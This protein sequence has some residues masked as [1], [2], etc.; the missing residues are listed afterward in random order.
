MLR[1]ASSTR[2]KA[3]LLGE[4]A[5]LTKDTVLLESVIPEGSSEEP[6]PP[7]LGLQTGAGSHKPVCRSRLKAG[8]GLEHRATRLIQW[9]DGI[10][11]RWVH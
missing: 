4:A 10:W 8:G 7:E 3:A 1:E 11:C 6:P 2:M 9:V 5:L